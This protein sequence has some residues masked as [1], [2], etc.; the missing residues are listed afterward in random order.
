MAG[1][2]GAPAT[3]MREPGTVPNDPAITLEMINDV[4]MLD[5]NVLLVLRLTV[6]VDNTFIVAMPRAYPNVSNVLHAIVMAHMDQ[7]T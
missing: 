2:T 5:L 1:G 6:G 4:G 3:P 7:L